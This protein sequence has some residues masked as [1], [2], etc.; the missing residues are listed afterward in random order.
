MDPHLATLL[1]GS[2][3]ADNLVVFCG[4]GLSMASPSAVPSARRLAMD[5]ST[6]YELAI[7]A[8]LPPDAR[9]NLETQCKFALD[10]GE[11]QKLF[12]EKL[13]AW[14]P[15]FRDPN[16]GHKAIADFLGAGV[17][18]FGVTTNV[19]FLV[20][21]AAQELGEDHFQAALNAVEAGTA[22]Q[23]ASY[24]KI[25]GCAMLDKRNTLWC[26]EQIVVGSP[27][28]NRIDSFKIWLRAN[29]AGRDLVFIGF[30]SDWDYLIKIL[31]DCVTDVEPNLVVLVDPLPA[32]DLEA[33]APGLWTWAKGPNCN[34]HHAQ[35]SGADFLDALRRR[36][37]IQ[38][39]ETVIEN[40]KTPYTALTGKHYTRPNTFDTTLSADELYSLR[41]DIEGLP[42]SRIARKKV[43]DAQMQLIGTVHMR[44]IEAGAAFSG[45]RYTFNS[46]RI[47]VLQGAGRVLSLTKKQF[48]S[49]ELPIG[50]DIVI[51]VGADDDG[52]VPTSIVRGTSSPLLIRPLSAPEWMNERRAIG[53]LKI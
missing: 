41:R 37:S 26:K 14:R 7:G 50:D 12:L 3:S 23:H 16:K 25:H 2:I 45:P 52:G 29:L 27:L 18:R 13:V 19:D 1:L 48:D 5:C 24:N 38:F 8:G 4:A 10:R 33:K 28:Q 44:L 34:F 40:A 46:K 35:E 31:E 15:F 47:R 53:D 20:E 32:A 6:K 49:E 51:C 36:F 30:W 11:L 39:L 17:L 21:T 9:D 43:P 22:R 42:S